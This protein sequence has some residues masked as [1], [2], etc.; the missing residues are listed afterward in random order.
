MREG[1][2][3]S[4]ATKTLGIC[5]L[6]IFVFQFGGIFVTFGPE[7]AKAA[8]VSD[9]QI[10]QVINSIIVEYGHNITIDQANNF[11]T[12]GGGDIR[13]DNLYL[14]GSCL[15]YPGILRKISE[16]C[17]YRFVLFLVTIL[18]GLSV[19]LYGCPSPAP[20]YLCNP[21]NFFCFINVYCIA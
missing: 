3:Q 19:C 15:W 18:G 2:P 4:T 17:T 6:Y 5:R 11:R 10:Q 20:N 12:T 16:V 9:V 21:L 8:I 14:N 1:T 13:F 7:T